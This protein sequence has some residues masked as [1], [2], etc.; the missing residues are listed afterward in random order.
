[1]ISADLHIHSTYSD[2]KLSPE[3]IVIKASKLNL[4][5]ISITD[6]DTIDGILPAISM[7]KK[8][9]DIEIIPGVEISTDYQEN[10]IHILGYFIDYDSN[11][12]KNVLNILQTKRELRI[13][14]IVKKL[15]DIGIFITLKDVNKISKGPSIGR[16]HIAEALKRKNYAKTIT[17][18]FDLY[19]GQNGKAYVPREKLSPFDAI[20]IIKKSK[21]IPILAHPGHLRKIE[22]INKLVKHGLAGLEVYHK[23]HN[24]K[25]SLFY[26]Q[27][28]KKSELLI[29][30][31]SDC[32]GTKPIL[33][34]KYGIDKATLYKLKEEYNKRHVF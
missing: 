1:M 25:Q 21:G 22:I 29:T 30:G 5:A 28:A 8:L 11:Y 16:P 14:K 9:G 20:K 2:G 31:G 27:F 19:L 10:E 4:S 6:H 15:N 34:G 3:Q 24:N 13:K 33:I 7:A 17:E 18:A 26:S 32:H 23:D 12:L